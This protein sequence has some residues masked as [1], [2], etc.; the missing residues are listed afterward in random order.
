MHLGPSTQ[1]K[2]THDRVRAISKENPRPKRIVDIPWLF[3]SGSLASKRV[4]SQFG[5]LTSTSSSTVST[6]KS[7]SEFRH[8][9]ITPGDEDRGRSYGQNTRSSPSLMS[10]LSSS[11]RVLERTSTAQ[12]FSRRDSEILVARMLITPNRQ[13]SSPIHDPYYK[14]GL[15][16]GC[17]P[18]GPPSTPGD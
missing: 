11:T 5:P 14:T 7:S 15:F 18:T 9:T 12:L 17:S 6:N 13:H 3:Q 16:A 8:P 10:I 4:S 2:D 1:R